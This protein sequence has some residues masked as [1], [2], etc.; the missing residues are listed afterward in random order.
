MKISA[1]EADQFAA[2]PNPKTRA[3][4]VYGPD[5][6]LVRE[7]MNTLLRSV[8][9]DIHDPF[10]I[11]D[12]TDSDLKQ[13]P[14]RLADEAAAIAMLGG[15]RIVRLRGAG[16]AA[17]KTLGSFLDDP[18]GDAL[19]IVEGGD[20]NPRSS[21]RKLFEDHALAAAIPCYA[22][23]AA[24]LGETI[25]K[26]LGEDGLSIEPAAMHYLTAHLGSD[27]G[28][29]LNE[30]EKLSL[31]MGPG[32]S[33]ENKQVSLDDVRA[34]IGDNVE[35][36]MDAVVDAAT[37]GDLGALDIALARARS[38]DVH[39]V[40]L[41][42]AL[43]RHLIQLHLAMDSLENGMSPDSVVA[44]M[45]PPV[46]FSRKPKMQR[47]LGLWNRRRIER[48]LEIVAE[49]DRQCKTTGLPEK[50][51]CGQTLMRIAQAANAARR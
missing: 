7:R 45:R 29:T 10:R 15:R 11:S 46:H 41:L 48:A 22:D 51:I 14:A 8:V 37:G 43:T 44:S 30:L 25:R 33:G 26:K 34:C 28:V 49:A 1:R 40:A 47:Q 12:L 50:A 32:S 3:V 42:N 13:D 31:Y 36:G 39:S 38:A 2:R 4:L 18:K 5:N 35:S 21:L 6:G 19:I 20:L 24:T 16:D 23:N 27:R 9:E 17:S